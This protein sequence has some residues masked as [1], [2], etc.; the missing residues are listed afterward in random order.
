ML[1]L[2]NKLR[3]RYQT[4]IIDTSPVLVLSDYAAL[5]G[6]IDQA[7][8]TVRWRETP[9]SAVRTMF[10]ELAAANVPLGGVIL[11][12]VELK[13]YF[14]RGAKDD[15]LGYHKYAARYHQSYTDLVK[16]EE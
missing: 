5:A 4:I 11:N 6:M 16:G 15:Y 2:L 13:A 9:R 3:Q 12:R 7:V 14:G 8:S 1:E 10:K